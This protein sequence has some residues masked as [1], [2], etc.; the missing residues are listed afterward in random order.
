M[1]VVQEKELCKRRSCAREGVVQHKS[2]ARAAT[3]PMQQDRQG[4][5]PMS[6]YA[7]EGMLTQ[8]TVG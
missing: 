5:S 1:E 3:R 4:N 6:E 2:Q 8:R 7:T